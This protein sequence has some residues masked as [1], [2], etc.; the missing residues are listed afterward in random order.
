MNQT[1]LIFALAIAIVKKKKKQ[2]FEEDEVLFDDKESI[3][4]NNDKKINKY[5]ENENYNKI[6]DNIKAIYSN[7]QKTNNISKKV[8]SLS[9]NNPIMLLDFCLCDNNSSP[10]LGRLKEILIEHSSFETN[11]NNESLIK[12][13]NHLSKRIVQK[14]S[15]DNVQIFHA[16][17]S[18][19]TYLLKVEDNQKNINFLS[20][21]SNK[22]LTSS[23]SSS[24]SSSNSNIK[25]S[26]H[27][28]KYKEEIIEALN[29]SIL[30]LCDSSNNFKID[31]NS[32]INEN[33]NISIR[34]N[35]LAII[36][37]TSIENLIKE[38]N[39]IYTNIKKIDNSNKKFYIK[40]KS[41]KYLDDENIECSNNIY[42]MS[43]IQLIGTEN[44]YSLL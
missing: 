9:N 2:K 26:Q 39:I 37:R 25:I 42:I 28:I 34:I 10:F 7:A 16:I 19:I 36:F 29:D 43:I 22:N 11:N 27:G 13:K 24:S 40:K 1:F 4:K 38:S 35:T 15:V 8:T 3:F 14:I 12:F 41:S 32:D 5:N 31:I 6:F 23:S 18:N 30:K 21:L 17:L 20:S 44:H 33:N